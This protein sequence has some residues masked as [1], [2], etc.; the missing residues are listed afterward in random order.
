[1]DKNKLYRIE[2]LMN[3]NLP[4]NDTEGILITNKGTTFVKLHPVQIKS[5]TRVKCHNCKH[6]I[7]KDDEPEKVYC[8]RLEKGISIIMHR[9]DFCSLG[10]RE[11]DGI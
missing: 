1:M 2:T 5:C 4:E 7:V 8:Q 6:G 11:N 9:D 10:E 3:V